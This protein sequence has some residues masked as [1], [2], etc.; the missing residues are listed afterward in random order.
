MIEMLVKEGM[1]YR[2]ITHL[3]PAIC[4]SDLLRQN[5]LLHIFT[6]ESIVVPPDS[7]GSLMS[8]LSTNLQISEVNPPLNSPTTPPTVA[9]PAG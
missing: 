3:R 7:S 6:K 5:G 8:A 9:E 2:H 1:T 4:L